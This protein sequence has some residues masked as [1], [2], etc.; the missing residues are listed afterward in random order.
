MG[1]RA[2]ASRTETSGRGVTVSWLS[3]GLKA[4]GNLAKPVIAGR[5]GGVVAGALGGPIGMAAGSLV[6]G[7]ISR[8]RTTAGSVVPSPVTPPVL[9]GGSRPGLDPMDIL[10]LGFGPKKIAPGAGGQCPRGYH[11][12]KKTGRCVR[13]RKMNYANGRAIQRAVRRVKGAEKMFRKVFT[14]NHRQAPGK[15]MPKRRRK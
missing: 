2:G 8:P 10:T 4:I 6:A 9:Y 11:V 13:N 5:V 1:A 3:S 14:I 15:I 12:S 7:A